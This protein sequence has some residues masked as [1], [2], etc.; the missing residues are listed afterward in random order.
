MQRAWEGA[1]AAQ[2]ALRRR[3]GLGAGAK[4][5]GVGALVRGEGPVVAKGVAIHL[6][7][8]RV[9]ALRVGHRTVGIGEAHAAAVARA[10]V[11]DP[12]GEMAASSCGVRRACVC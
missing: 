7:A 3:R 4:A 8:R 1:E 11:G 9:A 12:P 2:G 5:H 6:G 10:R